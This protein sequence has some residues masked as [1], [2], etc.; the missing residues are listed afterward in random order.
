M[1]YRYDL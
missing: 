1:T